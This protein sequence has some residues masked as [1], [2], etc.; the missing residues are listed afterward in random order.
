MPSFSLEP[1]KTCFK[2]ELHLPRRG[3]RVFNHTGIPP[4]EVLSIPLTVH[5]NLIVEAIY[6]LGGCSKFRQL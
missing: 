2:R 3:N 6:G 4:T 5:A 1:F